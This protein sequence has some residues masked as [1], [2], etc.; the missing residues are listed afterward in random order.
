MLKNEYCRREGKALSKHEIDG[1]PGHRQM[2]I[3]SLQHAVLRQRHGGPDPSFERSQWR[4]A[5]FDGPNADCV[6]TSRNPIELCQSTISHGYADLGDD[7]LPRYCDGLLREQSIRQ[8]HVDEDL[9]L[10]WWYVHFN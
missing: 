2:R 4:A 9:E 3:P 5:G 8:D 7:N 6:A 1:C 10:G